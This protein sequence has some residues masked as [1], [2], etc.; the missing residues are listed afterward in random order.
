MPYL[1]EGEGGPYHEDAVELDVLWRAEDISVNSL[2]TA[3]I[4]SSLDVIAEVLSVAGVIV[5]QGSHHDQSHQTG[6]ENDDHEGIEDGEP[7]DLGL[8]EVVLEIAIETLREGDGG[9]DPLSRVSEC[10][11]PTQHG[12]KRGNGGNDKISILVR[13]HTQEAPL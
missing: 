12:I 10:D 4:A 3:V 5:V 2:P 9:L 1:S 11:G 8:E 6:E 13:K 7:V